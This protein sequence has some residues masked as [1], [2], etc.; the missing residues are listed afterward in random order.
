MKRKNLGLYAAGLVVALAALV[1]SAIIYSAALVSQPGLAHDATFPLNLQ[2]AAIASMSAQATYSSATFSPE[3]LTDGQT[4]TGSFNV[5]SNSGLAAASAT[6]Q[7]TVT[8]T[9]GL[10]GATLTLPGF[11]LRNGIDWATQATTALTAQSLATALRTVPGLQVSCAS[12][13][14]VIYATAPASGAFYNSWTVTTN[15]PSSI[16]VANATFTGG[17]DNARVA[18]NGVV[19]TQ[20]LA[21]GWTVGG[22]ASATA[23]SIASAINA[24]SLLSRLVTATPSGTAVNLVSNLAGVNNFGLLSSAP[25]AVVPSGATMIGGIAPS[26]SLST[27]QIAIPGN[28][29]TL[30]LPVLY[31]ANGVQLGGLTDQTTYYAIPLANGNLQL[32]DSQAH[33]VAGTFVTLTS[34]TTQS[35]A[36]TATLTAL[37]IAGTPSFKWQVSNDGSN[38][39]DLAISSVTVSSYSNPPASTVWSFG[40]LPFVWIRLNAVGPTAGGLNLQVQVVGTN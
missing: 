40:A 12:G 16:S 26:A 11:V 3:S 32:A 15:A 4:S 7:I 39:S 20:G 27:S 6:N 22:S 36:N 29:F 34:S 14:S 18:I 5:A 19:L 31:S 13:S 28:A 35:S 8:S 9:S 1:K 17:A 25:S 2:A 23:S 33:A 37:P 30:A 21:G 38:W 10:S 24:N